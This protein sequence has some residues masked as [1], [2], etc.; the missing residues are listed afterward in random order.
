MLT[1]MT[2][3]TALI[4]AVGISIQEKQQQIAAAVTKGPINTR[5]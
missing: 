5:L 1:T 4:G 3:A 2:A